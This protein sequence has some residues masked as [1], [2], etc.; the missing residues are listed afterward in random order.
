LLTLTLKNAKDKGDRESEDRAGERWV[1]KGSRAP[2]FGP[3]LLY[4]QGKFPEIA[5]KN[6]LY[7]ALAHTVRDRLLQRC[8]PAFR[9]SATAAASVTQP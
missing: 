4:V 8:C 9:N 2:L 3:V 1:A 6:D 7:M 5:T